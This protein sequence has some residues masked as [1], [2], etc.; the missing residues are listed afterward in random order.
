VP[1][2][3]VYLE[4]T[5]PSYLTARPSRDLLVA[6]HQQLTRE[7]WEEERGKYEL[8]ISPRVA[9]EARR[10]DPDAASQ[11]LA[12]LAEL[13][14]LEPSPSVDELASAIFEGL[15]V[16]DRAVGDAMHL[17]YAMHYEVDYLL[18]WNC[19]HL[20]N[21]ATLKALA[22]FAQE[23]GL[24]LPIVCTPEALMPGREGEGDVP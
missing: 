2:S 20:A 8:L 9:E 1:L 10:G 16:P 14:M 12:L 15:H 3:T 13:S 22:L 24:W 18:T 7:W 23:S 4:T 17:A 21:A 5:I 19:A 11:R 6:A